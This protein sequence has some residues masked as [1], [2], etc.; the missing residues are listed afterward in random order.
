MFRGVVD[1]EVVDGGDAGEV[2]VFDDTLGQSAALYFA[3]FGI[4]L[5]FDVF[6]DDSGIGNYHVEV[7]GEG[8]LGGFCE[9]GDGLWV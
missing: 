8:V 7:P 2:V 1:A 9:G 4:G 6:G 3:G 5:V